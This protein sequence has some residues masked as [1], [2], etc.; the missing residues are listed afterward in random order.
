MTK[1]DDEYLAYAAQ[2]QRMADRTINED[3]KRTWLRLAEA[4]LRMPAARATAGFFLQTSGDVQNREVCG[5]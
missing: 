5:R 1:L 4:W 2:C 3:D